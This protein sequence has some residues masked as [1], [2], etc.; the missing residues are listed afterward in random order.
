MVSFQTMAMPGSTCLEA[1]ACLGNCCPPT[2][3]L[4]SALYSSTWALA[5][6]PRLEWGM[7][8]GQ[9]VQVDPGLGNHVQGSEQSV[10]KINWPQSPLP[11]L[12]VHSEDE[13]ELVHLRVNMCLMHFGT[14]EYEY[15]ERGMRWFDKQGYFSGHCREWHLCV[16]TL[17]I[18][19]SWHSLRLKFS[20]KNT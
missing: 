16:L 4:L 15:V 14:T 13:V 7:Q 3:A 2:F 19:G 8:S 17:G 20:L 11:A 6:K 1:L 18:P 12:E 5:H 9:G 10:R